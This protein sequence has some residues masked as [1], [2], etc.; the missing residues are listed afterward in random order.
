MSSP[1]FASQR[2]PMTN[3]DHLDVPT[4]AAAALEN[5]A[6]ARVEALGFRSSSST[7]GTPIPDANGLGWPG[8]SISAARAFCAD[9]SSQIHVVETQRIPIRAQRTRS[10][11]RRR[12]SNLAREY[13]RRP[14]SRRVT[15]HAS[16]V[17]SGTVMDDKRLRG[18]VIRYAILLTFCF[19]RLIDATRLTQM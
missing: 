7:P 19:P 8:M 3:G 1:A 11:A 9:N 12:S 2:L 18:E 6:K 15:T 13:R 14:R 5:S 10:Q 4:A 17:C 16:A